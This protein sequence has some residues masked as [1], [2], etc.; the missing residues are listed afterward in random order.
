MRGTIDKIWENKTT[1]GTEYRTLQIGDQRYNV[2]DTKYFDQLQE[3][4]DIEFDFK[5][6]GKYKHITD[7]TLSGS[8]HRSN[9]HNQNSTHNNNYTPNHKER[10]IARMSCLKSASE[11]LAP[12]QMDPDAKKDIVID[13]AKFFERYV[14]EDDIGP[15]GY[16]GQGENRA[17][18]HR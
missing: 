11:I 14:F 4:E 12:V 3:G 7:M 5:E 1:K 16:E 15:P 2:W 8:G 18:N 13:T 6:S 17:G 9:N 10:Q